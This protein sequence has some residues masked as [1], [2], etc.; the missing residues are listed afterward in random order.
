MPRGISKRQLE[1]LVSLLTYSTHT[2]TQAHTHKQI[3]VCHGLQAICTITE[4]KHI[5]AIIE[6]Y[7]LLLYSHV[8]KL[9]L[10]SRVMATLES[11]VVPSVRTNFRSWFNLWVSLAPKCL[12]F[13]SYNSQQI[14]VVNSSMPESSHP[15]K[16]QPF[17]SKVQ[18]S[19]KF[20]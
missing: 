12:L 20:G 18:T 14:S 2:H 11:C 15:W 4:R 3:N 7:Q 16:L 10:C 19:R 8:C 13:V 1:Q 9:K 5:H 17:A 6:N